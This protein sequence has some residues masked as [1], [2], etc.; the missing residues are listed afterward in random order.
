MI[1]KARKKPVTINFIKY[2]DL[3]QDHKENARLRLGKTIVQIFG[4]SVVFEPS[5]VFVIK[6]PE[7]DIN[8]AKDDVLIIDRACEPY[9]CNR[10]IFE[11]NYDII[12]EDK[13]VF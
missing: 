6:T 8:M 9:T 1:K 5:G 11:Q 3:L 7:G 2:E 13:E 4:N 10:T 12:E